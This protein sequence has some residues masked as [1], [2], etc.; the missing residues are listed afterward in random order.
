MDKIDVSLFR[1]SLKQAAVILKMKGVPTH[2]WDLKTLSRRNLH[3]LAFQ[4][5]KTFHSRSFVTGLK[6]E[7]QTKADSKEWCTFICN[8]FYHRYKSKFI[9]II[10]CISKASNAWE[11]Y[12]I[13]IQ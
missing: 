7:L 9:Q 11:N 13:R 10:H 4:K 6:K 12:F 2:V 3:D 5:S 1:N 8:L